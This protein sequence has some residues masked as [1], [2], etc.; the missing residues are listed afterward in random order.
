MRGTK[1]LGEDIH[2]R[3]GISADTTEENYKR[4]LEFPSNQCRGLASPVWGLMPLH[5]QIVET[6]RG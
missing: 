3:L 1:G 5:G 6:K 2:F 4:T